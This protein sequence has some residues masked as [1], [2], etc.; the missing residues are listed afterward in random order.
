MLIRAAGT[1]PAAPPVIGLAV[2]E[3]HATPNTPFQPLVQG[4]LQTANP[5]PAL[6]ADLL[7]LVSALRGAPR[8]TG[9]GCPPRYIAHFV[10]ILSIGRSSRNLFSDTRYR[11]TKEPP[12]VSAAS[13]EKWV[14]SHHMTRGRR[15][16]E[17]PMAPWMRAQPQNSAPVAIGAVKRILINDLPLFDAAMIVDPYVRSQG[18]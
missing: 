18:N 2:P 1:T 17:S 10:V 9:R 4:N 7:K 12:I 16:P 6:A 8:R 15:G 5:H 11:Q 3:D 13:V 14:V